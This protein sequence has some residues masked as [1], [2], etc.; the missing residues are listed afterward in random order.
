MFVFNVIGAFTDV[1]ERARVTIFVKIHSDLIFSIKNVPVGEFE[2]ISL[3]FYLVSLNSPCSIIL[4]T[5]LKILTKEYSTY[6]A[7]DVKEN[8]RFSEKLKQVE[9]FYIYRNPTCDDFKRDLVV[10]KTSPVRKF[11]R[12]I[13]FFH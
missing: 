3:K 8:L 12:N 5:R 6:W 4:Q 9:F 11:K 13:P 10:V 7:L 2:F 1:L